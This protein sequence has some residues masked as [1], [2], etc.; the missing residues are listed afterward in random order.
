MKKNK[1]IIDLKEGK[2]EKSTDYMSTWLAVYRTFGREPI[3][4]AKSLKNCWKHYTK[5]MYKFYDIAQK[6]EW[7]ENLD[8]KFKTKSFPSSD[9]TNH[10]YSKGWI[11]R[12]VKKYPISDCIKHFENNFNPNLKKIK[13]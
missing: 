5:Q 1:V 3:E 13:L 11:M 10:R 8:A 12:M 7:Y 4:K 9:D 6:N 2:N